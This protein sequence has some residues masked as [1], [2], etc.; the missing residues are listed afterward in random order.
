MPEGLAEIG[1]LRRK[2]TLVVDLPVLVVICADRP[3]L[4]SRE[5]LLALKSDG[6]RKA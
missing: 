2:A 6:L 1:V 3:L 4:R 5:R